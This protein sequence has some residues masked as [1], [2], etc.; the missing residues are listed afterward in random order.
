MKNH[1]SGQ[2]LKVDGHDN[3]IM[4]MGDSFN[5]IPVLVYDSE[6]IIRNLMENDSMTHEEALEFF[7]YNIVGSYNGPGMPIFLHEYEEL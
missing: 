1:Y 4:G 3:A 6:K 2:R 5:R 7:D